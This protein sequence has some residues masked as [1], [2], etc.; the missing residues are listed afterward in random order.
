MNSNTKENLVN[1]KSFYYLRRKVHIWGD[2]VRI[3]YGKSK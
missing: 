1:T 2:L 3:R